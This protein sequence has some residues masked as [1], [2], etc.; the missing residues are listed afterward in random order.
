MHETGIRSSHYLI[1]ED[2]ITYA[3]S[4]ETVARLTA[5]ARAVEV[6]HRVGKDFV[7][8]YRVSTVF[9]GTDHGYG[10]EPLLFE[11]MIFGG[12]FD[13]LDEYQERCATLAE[14]RAQHQRAIDLAKLEP[15]GGESDDTNSDSTESK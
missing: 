14:A 12:K 8:G 15:H 9:L 6:Q 7:N 3:Y 1:D 13:G 2:G 5:W 10:G 11:T 4:V